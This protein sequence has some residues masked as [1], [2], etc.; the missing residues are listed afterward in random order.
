MQPH[1]LSNRGAPSAAKVPAPVIGRFK[2][3]DLLGEGATGLVFLAEDPLLER[4]IAL[5]IPRFADLDPQSAERFLRQ[6]RAT[7]RLRHPAIVAVFESGQIDRELYIASEYIEGQTLADEIDKS[8]RAAAQAGADEAVCAAATGMQTVEYAVTIVSELADALDYAH[9]EGIIHRDVK[10]GNVMIDTEGRPH[11]ADFG[12]ARGLTEDSHLTIAGHLVGTPAYMSP[13]QARG[14]AHELGPSS[15]LYALG[16]VL[17]ELLTGR[18]PFDGPPHV[19]IPKVIYDPPPPPRSIK[20]SLP[21]DLDVICLKCLAKDPADRYASCRELAGDLQSWLRGD[22]ISVRQTPLWEL[23]W[24]WA[25]KHRP[26]AA[27]A[28]AI[29]LLLVGIAAISSAAAVRLSRD[30]A[31]KNALLVRLTDQQQEENR[32][33]E[34]AD[35]AFRDAQKQSQLAGEQY[36]IAEGHAREAEE[37]N[38]FAAE[39][40]ERL[41]L[42]EPR[43]AALSREHQKELERRGRFETTAKNTDDQAMRELEKSADELSKFRDDLKT[44][45]S[46]THYLSTLTFVQKAIDARNFDRARRLLDECDESHRA[47]EWN[48]L[49]LRMGDVPVPGWTAAGVS[50]EFVAQPATLIGEFETIYYQGRKHKYASFS[51]NGKLLACIDAGRQIKLLDAKTGALVKTLSDQ[52]RRTQAAA[53]RGKLA[54][55]FFAVEFSPDKKHV[56]ALSRNRILVWDY[57]SG[58]L[59]SVAGASE[60]GKSINERGESLWDGMGNCDNLAMGYGPNGQLLVVAWDHEL[61][62]FRFERKLDGRLYKLYKVW[63]SYAISL[64]DGETGSQFPVSGDAREHVTRLPRFDFVLSTAE[65]LLFLKKLFPAEVFG[66]PPVPGVV[67]FDLNTGLF[68]VP[69][70]WTFPLDVTNAH[71]REKRRTIFEGGIWDV[72]EQKTLLPLEFLLKDLGLAPDGT[73]PSFAWSPDGERI[74]LV[75]GPTV[76]VVHAPPVAG[77][78]N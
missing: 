53:A 15:D 60:A 12:L 9:R 28:A 57:A 25:R 20:P 50:V 36:R 14:N 1:P 5:K 78:A 46:F 6:A 75:V 62:A 68:D 51:P 39:A 24:R 26:E 29:V 19:V 63:T 43:L 8:S 52:T 40:L 34:T 56:A 11:L 37:N 18:V 16:V 30:R 76:R 70:E 61:S 74:A 69:E 13:E 21:R 71:D 58:E 42:E 33:R 44:A 73:P 35:K 77:N 31:K 66:Q 2:I 47:W 54:E 55:P 17:Y 4:Q 67:R 38:R 7:A 64:W 27:L 32:Q 59:L 45:E 65:G 23:A 72:K 22:P 3:R 10:P 41:E 49:H 48:Y